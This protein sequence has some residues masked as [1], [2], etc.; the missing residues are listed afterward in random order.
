ME[1]EDTLREM[2]TISAEMKDF[3]GANAWTGETLPGIR[4]AYTH[5]HKIS[6]W[7]KDLNAKCLFPPND[8]TT[9]RLMKKIEKAINQVEA[10]LIQIEK[11]EK[12]DESITFEIPNWPLPYTLPKDLPNKNKRPRPRIALR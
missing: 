11:W 8:E 12:A 6:K 1:I 3:G 2:N 7:K 9:E 4:D 10:L 5:L